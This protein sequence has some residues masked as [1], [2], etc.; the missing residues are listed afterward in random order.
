MKNGTYKYVKKI[1]SIR[2]DKD[3]DVFIADKDS[4]Q[5]YYQDF[6]INPDEILRGIYHGDSDVSTIFL[7][8]HASLTEILT[9]SEHE[10]IHAAISHILAEER[11]EDYLS[12]NDLTRIDVDMEH[13]IIPIIQWIDD[14]LN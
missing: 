2:E 13:K 14:Y 7:K 9:T 11:E 8:R 4:E 10:D 3:Y 6:K 12:S 5:D 1:K